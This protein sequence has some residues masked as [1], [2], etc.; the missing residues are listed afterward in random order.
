MPVLAVD[1]LGHRA[2]LGPHQLA[3]RHQVAGHRG[4]VDAGQP[5]DARAVGLRDPEPNGYAGA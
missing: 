5:I 1:D 4:D 2:S 3:Q